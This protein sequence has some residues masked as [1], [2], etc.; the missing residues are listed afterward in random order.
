MHQHAKQVGPKGRQ[1]AERLGSTIRTFA[2]IDTKAALR[3]KSHGAAEAA[4]GQR[5]GRV[6][7]NFVTVQSRESRQGFN[8]LPKM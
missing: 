1:G 8:S 3:W 2:G 4:L 5:T 6:K 7:K